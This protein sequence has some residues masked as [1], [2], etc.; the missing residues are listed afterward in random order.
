MAITAKW[1]QHIEAWQRSGGLSQAAY[2][3]A[4]Q[5]PLPSI[6]SSAISCWLI[7]RQS[8]GFTLSFL[9]VVYQALTNFRH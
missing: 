8:R 6:L 5:T 4:Q 9:Y 1:R 3:A 2:C 7:A